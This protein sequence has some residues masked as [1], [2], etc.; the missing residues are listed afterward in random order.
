MMVLDIDHFKRVN[1]TYGH[2]IGDL[3]LKGF[4]A[5]LEEA[6]RGGDLICRLGGE[7]FVVVMPGVDATRSGADRGTRAHDHEAPEFRSRR[8]GRR[9]FDHGLDWS[10]GMAGELGLG[11]ALSHGRPGALSVASRPAAIASLRT[12]RNRPEL[13]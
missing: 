11:R 9:G 1:D 3:V 12:R 10:R 7:E 4:A 8:R 13:R 5:G 6:V 2:D